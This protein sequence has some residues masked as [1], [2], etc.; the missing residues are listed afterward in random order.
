MKATNMG[1][2]AAG[3]LS[4]LLLSGALFACAKDPD[5]AS[6]AAPTVSQSAGSIFTDHLGERDLGGY[7]LRILGTAPDQAFGVRAV[8]AGRIELR[9][10]ERRRARAQQHPR[11]YI[12]L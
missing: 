9:P 3:A 7:T 1:R 5:E 4:A 10:R 2:I 11:R 6:S 12:Q 8:R